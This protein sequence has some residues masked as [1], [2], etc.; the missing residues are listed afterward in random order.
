MERRIDFKFFE[1][2]NFSIRLWIDRM[3][4]KNFGTMNILMYPKLVR[5]FYKNL[6]RDAYGVAST[7]KED[8]IEVSEDG[9]A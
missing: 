4:Q 2:Y 9:L 1:S 7:V 6:K 5:K 3:G 8:Q